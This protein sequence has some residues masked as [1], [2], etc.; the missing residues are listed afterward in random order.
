MGLGGVYRPI[1]VNRN[2]TQESRPCDVLPR[3]GSH[4]AVDA[5]HEAG[6]PSVLWKHDDK[7]AIVVGGNLS[8]D[9]AVE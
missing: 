3:D 2:V 5:L 8:W 4:P 7:T 9:A 1:G 6:E